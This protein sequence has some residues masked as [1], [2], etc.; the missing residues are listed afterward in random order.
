[1]AVYR[2]R[3]CSVPK[4]EAY[5]LECIF[6]LTELDTA[7]LNL[8]FASEAAMAEALAKVGIKWDSG[9]TLPDPKQWFTL[10]THRFHALGFTKVP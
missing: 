4:G 2:V 9:T 3:F 6:D 1:M 7:P 10:T 8:S 5:V